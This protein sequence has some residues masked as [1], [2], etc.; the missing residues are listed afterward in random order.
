MKSLKL[1]K[2]LWWIGALDP[3]LRVFDIIMETEFGTTYNSY[4]I[5]GS[6]KT[7][8]IETAKLK[9]FDQ[10]LAKLQEVVDV[11]DIDYIIVNHT[12]PDHVGSLY[13]LL[14]MNPN[15][16]VI[17]TQTALNFLKDIVNADFKKRAVKENDTL[18]LG[19]KTLQF[20]ILPNLHW[21]DTMYTYVK[22]E[23]YLF[24]CDSF[25]AHF[26]DD[27]VLLSKVDNQEGYQ[28]A[29]KYYYDMI[30][31]PFP[32]FMLKALKR[33]EGLDIKW[34]LTGH[35]PVI[36]GEFD[37]IF[38]QYKK[39]ATI[40]NPNPR[41]TVVIPYV[42]AYGYTKKLSESI[43]EGLKSAGDIDVHTYDLVETPLNTV[44]DDLFYA[45]GILLG[46]PTILGEALKPL[47]DLTSLMLPPIHGGKFASA[48]GSYG[49]SGEG[50]PH[51]IERLKQLRMKVSDGLSIKFNPDAV[52]QQL[53]FDFG[54]NFGIKVLGLD[55]IKIDKPLMK[56]WKCIICGE[57]IISPTR[58][59]ICPVCGAPAEQ[60][61]EIPYNE[62]TF[63]SETREN[64]LIIGG[65][66]A[67]VNAA[68]AIRLRNKVCNI[69]L[70][71][72]EDQYG[73][74]RPML[75]KNF[76]GNYTQDEFLIKNEKWYRDNNIMVTLGT[77]VAKFNPDNREVM[78][79]NGEFRQY[80]KLILATGASCFVPPI[81]GVQRD[82]VVSIR[83]LKDV[84]KI[85][86]LLPKV[87]HAL[88]IGGGILG[89]EAAWQMKLAG[90]AVTV[91]EV[92]P[93]LM[94]RQ[95]DEV[96]SARLRIWVEA[97]GITVYTGIQVAEITG[98]EQWADG[99][100][101]GDGRH[102]EGDL[103]VVSAGIKSNTELAKQAGLD[104]KR[105]VVVNEFMETSAKNVFAAG[106]CAE[107]NG[108][109]YAIWSQAVDMG[110]AAGANA[111]GDKVTYQ[112]ILPA[113][114]IHALDT[115]VFAIGDCGK[116][117]ELDYRS[118]EFADD[119]EPMFAKYFFTSGVFCGGVLLHNTDKAI[120]LTE[121]LGNKLKFSEFMKEEV[122]K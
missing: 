31:G 99:I 103:I 69:E 59:E 60:F 17:G 49:W 73:Y 121:A 25:G 12:E 11:K 81:I 110:K 22:E 8:V 106:D 30:L 76:M 32:N 16:E 27:K 74:N 83:H 53:A 7:A 91:L 66:A 88:V 42:S 78:L 21:P 46:T 51:L 98:K 2:D 113:V 23:G 15:I 68:E 67:A 45:D 44:V 4:V 104:V 28:R 14:E 108:V 97:K 58:P 34:I 54:Y 84:E 9:T 114:S 96:S 90:L 119:K 120:F 10:Y 65:G 19:D 61:I 93:A 75:T 50:V 94:L 24:T 117:P 89:L 115:D 1:T 26:C 95:M 55:K 72:E 105:A 86:H 111:S 82:N 36:D 87:S 63:V 6:E 122:K 79:E 101:L 35:G 71:S 56:A 52:K 62:V 92:A 107:F 38:A 112:P 116:N 20:F 70:I 118:V 64:V 48:F 100:N 29:L 40:V 85:K 37:R 80:D 109:N 5:K 41:K 33:I 77:A 3:D 47:W 39:W 57:I 102:L 43:V 18:S 13:K